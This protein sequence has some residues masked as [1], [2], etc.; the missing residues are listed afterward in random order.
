MD[1]DTVKVKRSTGLF[2]TMHCGTGTIDG[3]DLE[4]NA[5]LNGTMIIGFADDKHRYIVSVHDVIRAA[6][7]MRCAERGEPIPKDDD[8]TNPDD[9]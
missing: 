9:Q 2:L 3:V 5:A 7:K 6:Y 8:D 4:I 1:H